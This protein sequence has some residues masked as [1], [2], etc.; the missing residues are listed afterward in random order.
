MRIHPVVLDTNVVVSAHLNADGYERVVVDLAVAGKLRLYVTEDILAEYDGVLR[1]PKVGLHPA[2]GDA[3]LQL[4]RQRSRT[5]RPGRR[6]TLASDPDDNKFLECAVA[7]GGD[8]LVPGKKRHYPAV[9]GATRVVSARE[10]L[11]IVAPEL[12]R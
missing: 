8:S 6:L 1:R 11:H 9:V 12:R 7:A 3:A 5:V 4:I 2:L 10:L